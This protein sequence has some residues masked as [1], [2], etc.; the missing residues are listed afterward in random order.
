MRQREVTVT[1]NGRRQRRHAS[2]WKRLGDCQHLEPF[3]ERVALSRVEDPP[4][5]ALESPAAQLDTVGEGR[6][7]LLRIHVTLQVL[8][9]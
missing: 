8:R 9:P 4:R 2:R 3:C 7:A 1:E 5:L 6:A